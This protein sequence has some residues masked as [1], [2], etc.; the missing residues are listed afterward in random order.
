MLF[1]FVSRQVRLE[2]EW[3]KGRGSDAGPMLSIKASVSRFGE[4]HTTIA[5][6]SLFVLVS[7]R[8]S[9]PNFAPSQIRT[10]PQRAIR[11]IREIANTD[12]VGVL[13]RSFPSRA[14]NPL[15]KSTSASLIKDRL[16]A[17][18]TVYADG[19]KA[20]LV[21]IG[22]AKRPRSFPRLFDSVR[23]LG[24]FY[25]AQKNSW[26]TQHLW[27]TQISNM[28][29]QMKREFR[30]ILHIVDNCS[31]HCIHDSFS[32]VQTSFLPPNMASILQ[33]VDA[34]IGRSFKA[35]YRRLL[36]SHAIAHLKK[37]RK[38]GS[39]FKLSEAV[40]TYDG[41]VLMERAWDL[42]PRNVILNG[43]LTCN[44]LADHQVSEILALKKKYENV[45]VEVARPPQSGTLFDTD[46][47]INEARKMEAE[48][49]GQQY[50]E[51]LQV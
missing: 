9:F 45:V 46:R 18:L 30:T 23:D 51:Q 22:K 26:N 33:P 35:A 32:N 40:T 25:F 37:L 17:V 3:P 5:I 1:A 24:V 41:V 6:F 14:I 13:Y 27:E 49:K 7:T 44:I 21:I 10:H 38:D 36:V 42:V 19:T 50:L 28:N 15:D 29:E 39:P 31:A 2:R 43:W 47:I 4:K 12:E 48:R 11:H 16:T 34:A 20:P 8:P